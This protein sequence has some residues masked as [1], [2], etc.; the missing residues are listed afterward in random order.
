MSATGPV[1]RMT[2]SLPSVEVLALGSAVEPST[3]VAPPP[4]AAVMDESIVV[5]PTGARAP[6]AETVACGPEPAAIVDEPVAVLSADTSAPVTVGEVVTH[7]PEHSLALLAGV[8]TTGEAVNERVESAPLVA[9][10][11]TV[12]GVDAAVAS[13]SAAAVAAPLPLPPALPRPCRCLRRCCW[14][15]LTK[16]SGHWRRQRLTPIRWLALLYVGCPEVI[17]GASSLLWM[18][19]GVSL[20]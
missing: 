5:Q 19:R 1:V 6:V 8:S 12:P 17:P 3:P 15:S 2:E 14:K 18:M 20:P 7:V 10:S 16:A 13:T 11:S 9:P 4:H